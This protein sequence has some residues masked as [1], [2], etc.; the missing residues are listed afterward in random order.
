MNYIKYIHTIDSVYVVIRGVNV[1]GGW[2]TSPQTYVS[3][4]LK[5]SDILF[6]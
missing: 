5:M 2:Y 4:G 6:K 3:V 1:C